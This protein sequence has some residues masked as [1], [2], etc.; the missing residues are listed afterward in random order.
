VSAD[1]DFAQ[2]VN[3]RI[4]ILLPPPT[5][6]PKLGWRVLDAAGVQEKF[7][8]PPSG[9]ADYLALVGDTSDNI[10]GLNGV[11]PKTASKWLAEFGD[12]EGVIANA[13]K[14]KPDRF[15]AMVAADAAR[16]RLNRKLTTL[17]LALP[18]VVAEATAVR[19]AELF[20]LLEEME[21]RTALA[22]A[23]TRYEQRELF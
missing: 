15:Q 13:A 17:N 3:D 18:T 4:K 7:G 16:L 11:G 1:K 22:E 19:T 20:R 8:V 23:R 21:M 12:L 2:V 9:I 10:P 14:L 5:A 6:N